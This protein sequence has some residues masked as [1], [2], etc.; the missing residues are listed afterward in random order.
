MLLR[1]ISKHVNDQN[2]FAVGIDFLIVVFGV[3]MGIQLGNWNEDRK[4]QDLAINYIE[5][6]HTEIGL[7]TQLWDKAADYFVT[8]QNYG[9]IAL[10]GFDRPVD[11]LDDQFLIALYQASQVWYVAPNRATF[12]ELQSTGRIV[13]IKDEDLRMALANHY[14]R[15]G[16]TGF[17]L[18]QTSQYRRIARLFLHQD[19]QAQI[20]SKCGDSWITDENNFYFVRLPKFC[21]IDLPEELMKSEIEKMQEC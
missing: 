6:L 18:S 8:T 21:K 7:E 17:T 2:W 3:F 1:S 12:D 14:L 15:V 16:Q 5:R 9:R 19:V 20:R 11:E 10:H 13:N 4:N